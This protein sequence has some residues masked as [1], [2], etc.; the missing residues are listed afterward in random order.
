MFECYASEPAHKHD[1]PQRTGVLLVNLGTPD[2]PTPPAVKRYLREFLSDQ[3][4]VELPGWLWQPILHGIVL[5]TRPKKA[6]ARYAKIWTKD[7]SPLRLITEKQAKLVRGWLGGYRNIQVPVEYA[8]RY[9]NPSIAD[10]IGRLREANVTRLLIV[11]LFPQYSA[12]TTASVIDEVFRVFAGRRN[13]PQIR[14]VRHF[15]DEPA[16]IEALANRVRN[17]WLSNGGRPDHLL[18]SFH[19]LPKKNLQLGNPYF[20]ECHKTGRLLAEALE[21]NTNQFSITFQSRFGRGEWLKPYTD[22]RL[23]ELGREK[24][25]RLDVI[26]PGFMADCLETLEEIA[27]EGKATFLQA[28]GGEFRYIPALNDDEAGIKALAG[29][30]EQELQ[31]WPT[32]TPDPAALTACLNRARAQGASC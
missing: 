20:C 16:Y 1:T 5:N 7:G 21:L 13:I 27:Q 6:A 8:M 3:R 24:T 18:M 15:H 9:G 17:F 31:G 32:T 10:A 26:C 14:T 22:S 4:I 11:P 23:T 25:R 12:S 2:A 29:L 30:I 19:G 28:G